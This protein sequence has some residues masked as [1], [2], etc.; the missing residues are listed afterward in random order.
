MMNEPTNSAMTANVSRNMLK[1]L[2]PVWI[3]LL[4]LGG[5]LGA[6]EHLVCRSDTTL[7]MRVDEL[8]DATPSAATTLMA[9]NLPGSVMHRWA[10][11]GVNNAYDDAAGAVRAA[12]G[13]DADDRHLV[14]RRLG[15][16][17][18]VCRRREVAVLG[19]CPVD[20]DLVVVVRGAAAPSRR[21]GLS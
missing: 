10:A 18:D 1:K 8:A 9:S 21:N 16:H 3:V 13:G 5:D 6:G 2:R 7:A 12:E 17:R 14:R 11:S 19:R 4:V 20:H 15:R